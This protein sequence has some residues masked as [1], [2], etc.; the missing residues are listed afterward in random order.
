MLRFLKWIFFIFGGLALAIMTFFYSQNKKD[1]HLALDYKDILDQEYLSENCPRSEGNYLYPCF[2]KHYSDMVEKAGLTGVSMALKLA[3]NFMDEDKEKQTRFSGNEK[4]IVY[5]LNY[6]ELNNKAI[7]ES[8]ERFNGFEFMYGGYL[9]SIRDFLKGAKSFSEGIIQGLEGEKGISSLE[10]VEK[11]ELYQERLDELKA[12][13]ERL[14]TEVHD[15]NEQKISELL[16]KNDQ[17]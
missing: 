7:D 12:E 10:S 3:F 15:R 17:K 9:S 5:S 13:F 16:A 2:Y 1:I 14:Y 6:L 11:Q 8:D 4:D